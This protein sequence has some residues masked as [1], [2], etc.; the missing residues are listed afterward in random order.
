MAGSDGQIEIKAFGY[1]LI[2]N[3]FYDIRKLV[4]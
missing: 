1:L 2:Y 3:Y 4:L